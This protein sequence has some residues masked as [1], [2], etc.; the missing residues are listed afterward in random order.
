M[1]ADEN[2]EVQKL[3]S[4]LVKTLLTPQLAAT[5]QDPLGIR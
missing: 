4:E 2:A 5:Q 1:Q 3:Q